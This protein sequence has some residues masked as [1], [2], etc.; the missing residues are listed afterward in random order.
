[1]PGHRY[2][3]SVN[4]TGSSAMSFLLCH[5]C[6]TWVEPADDRCPECQFA[7]DLSEADPPTGI[8]RQVIGELVARLGNVQIPRRL[9]PEWGTL[10]A[11]TEGLFF[12][13]L[14]A[15]DGHVASARPAV[16][17]HLGRLGHLVWSPLRFLFPDERGASGRSPSAAYED[18]ESL[19]DQHGVDLP[20]LLMDHPGTFFLPKSQVQSIQFQRSRWTIER[21]Q[22]GR[23]V[24]SA[25]E[26]RSFQ[27]NFRSLLESPD[28][29][30]V[31]LKP[32]TRFL[33]FS[34]RTVW[35]S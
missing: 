15:D 34:R 8:L 30:I 19:L 6:Y 4:E 29:R 7:M 1:M 13:P 20:R 33:S 5:E 18:Q 12:L 9:L 28:W 23:L 22:G 10:Y 27:A 16:G 2:W 26:P 14:T 21:C 17:T 3:V 32:P 35:Q 11:T 25:A 31:P 24:L